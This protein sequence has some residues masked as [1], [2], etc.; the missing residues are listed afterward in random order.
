MTHN[1]LP[2]TEVKLTKSP[3]GGFYRDNHNDIAICTEF[4]RKYF[5]SCNNVLTI[6]AQ[7]TKP[8]KK[9]WKK[10]D[11]GNCYVRISGKNART[12]ILSRVHDYLNS[13]NFPSVF[14]I[15]IS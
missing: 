12:T 14:Y 6:Q 9:G 15:K 8:H 2:I 5:P 4:I 7:I 3:L 11:R 13:L 10:I 1:T